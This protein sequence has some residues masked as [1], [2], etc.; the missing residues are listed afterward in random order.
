MKNQF[1]EK[2]HN[3]ISKEMNTSFNTIR[4]R[5]IDNNIY[6]RNYSEQYNVR[7]NNNS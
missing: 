4:N 7:R 6:I 2:N 3:W 5:L 1:G